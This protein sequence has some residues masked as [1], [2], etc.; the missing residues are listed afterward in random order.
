MDKLKV[1]QEWE[2]E[3]MHEVIPA[4]HWETLLTRLAGDPHARV[5]HHPMC[6]VNIQVDPADCTHC[7]ELYGETEIDVDPIIPTPR[8]EHRRVGREIMNEVLDNN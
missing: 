4:Y 5:P 2:E 7:Q 8:Q 3:F 6:L 1:C